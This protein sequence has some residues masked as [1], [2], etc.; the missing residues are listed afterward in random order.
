MVSNAHL[1][2]KCINKIPYT[3]YVIYIK[4]IYVFLSQPFRRTK[5]KIV[6][7]RGRIYNYRE[8]ENTI[9]V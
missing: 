4:T 1:Y 5:K 3:L 2:R 6:F 7:K 9:I 8:I